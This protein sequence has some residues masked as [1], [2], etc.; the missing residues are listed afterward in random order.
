MITPAR[1][2]G[3]ADLADVLVRVQVDLVVDPHRRDHHAELAG[4]LAA[5]H[6]DAADQRAAGAA[7]DERHQAEADAE[8]ERVDRQ[9][10]EHL[11]AR[12]ALLGDRARGAR[13]QRR[14]AGAGQR[15]L[16]GLDPAV[17]QR[18]ADRQEHPADEEERE[19]RQPRDQR[20]QADHAAGH[21]RRLLLAEDLAGQLGAEVAL[22]SAERVTMM[23][24]ATEISSAG[25]C[26]ARPSPTVS[27][28]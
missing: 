22:A 25:I 24:V 4:D 19:L 26:A 8:L 23:P 13:R 17:A 9:L 15:R 28:E 7:V 16:E 20:E 5:D 11:V 1:D 3:A 2:L 12:R 27:S 18:P 14:H 6:R 21:Q 10:L